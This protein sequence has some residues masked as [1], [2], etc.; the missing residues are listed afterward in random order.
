MPKSNASH[1]YFKQVR[2]THAEVMTDVRE[3]PQSSKISGTETSI[4]ADGEDGNEFFS[5]QITTQLERS[6]HVVGKFLNNPDSYGQRTSPGRPR[7]ISRHE[8]RQILRE[9]S[10]TTISVGQIQ[11]NLN[12]AASR[13]VWRVT[14]ASPNIHREA[15]R[16]APRLTARHKALR[17][18]IAS[19]NIER[20]WTKRM[21]ANSTMTKFLHIVFD[22]I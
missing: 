2:R 11:V 3:C 10:N 7:V 8:E 9:V 17:L 6:R 20:N 16:K 13:T 21:G 12:L 22:M 18:R 4:I 1:L 15:T 14:N 5:P 19:E